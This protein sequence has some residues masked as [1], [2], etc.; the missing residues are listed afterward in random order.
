MS[1]QA[2]VA[3]L[4]ENLQELQV[5]FYHV[6][7]SIFDLKEE[8]KSLFSQIAWGSY[9]TDYT[10]S[11]QMNECLL[12]KL[13][14]FNW[15]KSLRLTSVTPVQMHRALL[16]LFYSCIHDTEIQMIVVLS[17]VAL[18][19]FC[20]TSPACKNTS[21]WQA[22]KQVQSDQV[23]FWRGSVWAKATCDMS[24]T[25]RH[26][27]VLLLNIYI[28]IYSTDRLGEAGKGL[29]YCS[30]NINATHL[31]TYV[32]CNSKHVRRVCLDMSLCVVQ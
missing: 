14:Y 10:L 27:N 32:H 31:S 6:N 15:E 30:Q 11:V 2:N 21:K 8:G 22:L 18:L 26:H 25:A 5:V 17:C 12:W 7:V 20:Q 1:H 16:N 4:G 19:F 3:T 9:S 13:I 24:S 28:Y 29:L 23:G